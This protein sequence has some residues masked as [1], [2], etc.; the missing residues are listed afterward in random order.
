MHNKVRVSNRESRSAFCA[1]DDST[2]EQE[3]AR[4]CSSRTERAKPRLHSSA[5][6]GVSPS[7]PGADERVDLGRS[8]ARRLRHRFNRALTL[9]P[10]HSAF[11][12][13]VVRT[14]ARGDIP[15]N[16]PVGGALGLH[17]SSVR[18]SPPV[19]RGRR[20]ACPPRGEKIEGI[21]SGG[22]ACTYIYVTILLFIMPCIAPLDGRRWCYR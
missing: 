20:P 8:L 5:T 14:H 17:G 11:T 16:L 21:A 9:N 7:A 18:L 4:N 3:P 15:A 19:R 10:L 12:F 1:A 13:D 6:R 22:G 2:L